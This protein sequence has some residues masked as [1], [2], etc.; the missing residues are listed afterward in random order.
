MTGSPVVMQGT[1]KMHGET[2]EIL[3]KEDNR[4][5]VSAVKA[6]LA[7]RL[8]SSDEEDASGVGS[9]MITAGNAE[10][11]PD[12]K[13]TLSKNVVI[14]DG[15]A[16]ITCSEMDIFL[17]KDASNSFFTANKQTKK[18]DAEED[19][20]SSKTTYRRSSAPAT[21]CT[22]DRQMDRNRSSWPA[23]RTTMPSTR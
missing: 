7:G 2:I 1:N 16:R 17:Q 14:D 5:I 8:L 12:E 22:A 11:R 21:S 9:T 4:V 10:F 18:D 15:S 23:R 6:Y 19:A 3:S 13:I 20:M